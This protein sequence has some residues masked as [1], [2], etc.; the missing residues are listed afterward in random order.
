M[1]TASNKI[2]I[3]I[4]LDTSNSA[5][6]D[7]ELNKQGDSFGIKVSSAQ[8]SKCLFHFIIDDTK[9]AI[10]PLEKI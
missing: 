3:S 5:E 9:F 2:I 10:K 4:M 8:S 1:I 7:A 6:F